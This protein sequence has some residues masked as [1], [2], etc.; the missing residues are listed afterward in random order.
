MAA[1]TAIM[2][3]DADDGDAENG[4][5]MPMDTYADDVVHRYA[6][7]TTAAASL[8][9]ALDE[10]IVETPDG[11]QVR[12]P[13]TNASLRNQAGTSHTAN[14]VQDSQQAVPRADPLRDN[15]SHIT[16]VIILRDIDSHITSTIRISQKAVPRA[17]PI[18][19]YPYTDSQITM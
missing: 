7:A 3:E 4:T 10:T 5:R 1:G 13:T 14:T 6:N 19:A 2:E 9:R 18:R 17:D 12:A 16:C 11:Q 8:G 15:D